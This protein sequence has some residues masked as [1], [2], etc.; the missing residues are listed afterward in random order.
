MATKKKGRK[1]PFTKAA[2][3]KGGRDANK[4]ERKRGEDKPHKGKRK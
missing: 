2:E 4:V 3:A 1:D